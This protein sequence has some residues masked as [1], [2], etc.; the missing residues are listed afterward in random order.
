MSRHS[1]RNPRQRKARGASRVGER[2][3]AVVGPVAHGGHCVARVA[4]DPSDPTVTRVVFTRHTLPGERVVIEITEGADDPQRGKPGAA[5]PRVRSR[6]KFWRP[7]VWISTVLPGK[8]GAYARKPSI[9]MRSSAT[10]CVLPI[11]L[12]RRR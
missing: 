9:G 8:S 11:R 3:E 1:N 4:A 10:S 5:L 6:A 2:F 7:P 12:Q